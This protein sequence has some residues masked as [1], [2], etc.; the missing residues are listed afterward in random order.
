MQIYFH[1]RSI[2]VIFYER[3]FLLNLLNLMRLMNSQAELKRLNKV[4]KNVSFI[5]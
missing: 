3:D 1:R 2:K 5:H 4:T